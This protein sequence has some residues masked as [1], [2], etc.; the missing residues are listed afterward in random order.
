LDPLDLRQAETARTSFTL[1][2]TQL[3]KKE[4]NSFLA[5]ATGVSLWYDA[6]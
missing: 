1:F 2:N 5:V 4:N 6:R 3:H